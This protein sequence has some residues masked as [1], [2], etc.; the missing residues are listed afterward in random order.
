VNNTI[1]EE[2]HCGSVTTANHRKI[3]AQGSVFL[4]PVATAIRTDELKAKNPQSSRMI[5]QVFERIRCQDQKPMTLI[6]Q[7]LGNSIVLSEENTAFLFQFG[8]GS[9]TGDRV[10]LEIGQQQGMLPL[11]QSLIEFGGMR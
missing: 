1:I 7:Q 11:S 10:A 4:L 2:S 6:N 5:C 3:G 8:S 9:L